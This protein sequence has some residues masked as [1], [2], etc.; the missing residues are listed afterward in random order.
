MRLLLSEARLYRDLE[1]RVTGRV[2]Q[3]NNVTGLKPTAGPF[4]RLRAGSST[5]PLAMKLREA[6]LRGCGFFYHFSE[7]SSA[8]QE[9]IQGFFA[10]L[11]MTN[12]KVTASQDDNFYI[13]PSFKFKRCVD[14][15]LI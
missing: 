9:K 3:K 7:R 14:I 1:R 13:N 10:S 5:A 11:R 12:K 4:D 2:G 15:C 8:L 6:P